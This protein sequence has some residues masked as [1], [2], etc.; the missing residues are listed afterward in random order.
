MFFWHYRSA[1]FGTI[2]VQFG[3]IAVKCVTLSQC[4]VGL[5]QCYLAPMTFSD[6]RDKQE[7][8]RA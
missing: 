3:T 4:N 5:S 7:S 8:V 2:A 1:G 6:S